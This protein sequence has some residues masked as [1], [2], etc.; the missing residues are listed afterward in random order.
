MLYLHPTMLSNYYTNHT[1][2]TGTGP[3]GAKDKKYPVAIDIRLMAKGPLCP[4]P[5]VN[6]AQEGLVIKQ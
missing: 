5:A 2:T 4:I 6:L 3:Q 1:N